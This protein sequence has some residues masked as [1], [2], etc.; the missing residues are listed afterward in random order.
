MLKN[1]KKKLILVGCNKD[2]NSTFDK[3]I[4][5]E[6]NL[7]ALPYWI[8]MKRLWFRYSP[9]YKMTKDFFQYF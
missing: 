4:F 6:R 5:A 8:K 7:T 9:C 1:K 2:F 3:S